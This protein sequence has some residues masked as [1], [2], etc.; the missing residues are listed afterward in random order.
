MDQKRNTHGRLKR[1]ALSA[2]LWLAQLILLLPDGLKLSRTMHAFVERRLNLLEAFVADLVMIRA[3]HLHHTQAH[4]RDRACVA[5]AQ[6]H[7]DVRTNVRH[8]MRAAMGG[9]LRRALKTRGDLKARAKAILH[10]LEHQDQLARAC[11]RRMRRSGLSRRTS[12]H[13]RVKTQRL[14]CP[15]SLNATGGLPSQFRGALAPP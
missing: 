6:S 4:V 3:A 14:Y 2:A 5:R 9:R 11:I 10:N 15:A 1:N 12:A 7:H 8:S 13:S